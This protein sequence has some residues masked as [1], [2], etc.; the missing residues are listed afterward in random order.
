MRFWT[1]REEV[2]GIMYLA[3][4]VGPIEEKD[5]LRDL[6][7]MFSTDLIFSTQIEVCVESSSSMVG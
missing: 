3:P 1:N 7:V 2:P 4:D 5:C 6:G